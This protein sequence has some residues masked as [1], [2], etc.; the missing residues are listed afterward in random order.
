[1]ERVTLVKPLGAPE[2]PEICAAEGAP[3]FCKK[4]LSLPKA[5]IAQMGAAGA[6]TGAPL[7]RPRPT[8]VQNVTTNQ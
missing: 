8:G 5:A 4:C 7:G 2:A 3:N 6:L 1:M